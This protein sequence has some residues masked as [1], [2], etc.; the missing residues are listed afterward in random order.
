MLFVPADV[1]PSTVPLLSLIGVCRLPAVLLLA[2]VRSAHFFR[3]GSGLGI[4]AC[5]SVL[6]LLCF[7]RKTSSSP[8]TAHQHTHTRTHNYSYSLS[9]SALV[10]TLL[11]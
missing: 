1:S 11:V 7:H 8:G 9:Q 10:I 6:L 2:C 3:F 4:P 5:F